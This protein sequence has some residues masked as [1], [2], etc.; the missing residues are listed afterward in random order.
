MLESLKHSAKTSPPSK[1]TST[2]FFT[3]FVHNY[4][5]STVLHPS[6]CAVEFA[7]RLCCDLRWT[8]ALSKT[9]G[10][11]LHCFRILIRAR[12]PFRIAGVGEPVH[13]DRRLAGVKRLSYSGVQ[14]VVA[15]ATPEGRFAVKYGLRI[16]GR[17]RRYPGHAHVIVGVDGIAVFGHVTGRG[18]FG[19]WCGVVG[20]FHVCRRTVRT[21]TDG[22]HVTPR[23]LHV[24]TAIF[25][26]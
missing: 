5:C 2:H 3:L 7:L 20:R 15:D 8:A 11:T 22:V 18:C 12:L 25:H 14:F 10:T 19:W 26:N 4:L 24:Q 23:M 13:R 1:I 9:Y 16:D 21:Q 17:T 6:L